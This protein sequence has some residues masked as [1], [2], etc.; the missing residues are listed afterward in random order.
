LNDRLLKL[1]LDCLS[2]E[3]VVG[4]EE[5]APQLVN[6]Q[7]QDGMLILQL[8]NSLARFSKGLP[9]EALW[10]PLQVH[11]LIRIFFCSTCRGALC[12]NASHLFGWLLLSGS[13]WKD[14]GRHWR[15]FES[16]QVVVGNNL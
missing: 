5:T 3:P 16:G 12:F 13:W 7:D 8:R 9:P 6:S 10:S 4:T 2:P 14:A 15:V 1:P 11:G